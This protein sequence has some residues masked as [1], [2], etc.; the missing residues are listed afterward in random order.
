MVH[1]PHG[2]APKVSW[3]FLNPETLGNFRDPDSGVSLNGGVSPQIIHLFIG[4][5]I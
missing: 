2:E 3:I 1:P 5:S 4:F